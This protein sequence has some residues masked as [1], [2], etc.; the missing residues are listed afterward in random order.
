MRVWKVSPADRSRRAYGSRAEVRDELGLQRV[1]GG[2][3]D[4]REGVVEVFDE[5]ALGA[6]V[7]GEMER[8]ER[9]GVVAGAELAGAHGVDEALD[10]GLAEEIDGLLGVADEEDG[11]GGAVPAMREEL[12]ELVLGGGRV[13]HL[14]DEEMLQVHP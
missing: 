4:L 2:G 9:E 7:G 6:E 8:R 12:D 3:K 13:L 10:A 11:L 14:V 1:G 5:G